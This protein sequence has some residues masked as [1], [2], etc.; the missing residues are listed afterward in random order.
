MVL[1]T[2]VS[3]ATSG[4]ATGIQNVIAPPPRPEEEEEEVEEE[5]VEE[6]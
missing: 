4:I 6:E 3:A 5:E 2:I 1:P